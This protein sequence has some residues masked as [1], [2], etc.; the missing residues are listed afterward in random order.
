MTRGANRALG[1]VLPVLAL[2]IAATSCV[3]LTEVP[4]TEVR[5]AFYATPPG[6]DQLVNATYE[7][8]RTFFGRERGFTMTIFGTDEY[9][10]GADGGHKFWNDYD[11]SLNG[12]ASFGRDT[13]TD[14]YLAIN[15]TNA[16]VARANDVPISAALRTLRVAEAR[17]L[18]AFYYFNLVRTFGDVP[19]VVEEALVPKTDAGRDPAAKVYDQIIADL[20]FAKANL[21]AVQKDY[22]RA[23][24]PA[25]QHLLAL[26][27]LTRAQ[28][29]DFALAAA[30]GRAVINGGQFKLLPR[31]ADLFVFG[32]KK[33]DE[34]IWSVQYTADP[35]TT[36]P[37]NNGH[38]FFLMAYELWPGMVRDVQNG[39]AFK[40]FRPT[41]WLLNLWGD[42][43]TTVDTRYDDS[44][45]N[46]WYANNAAT[47]PKKPDGSP[48]FTVGDT[49]IWMPGYLLTPAD[50][51]SRRYQVFSP[52]NY[53]NA[54]FPS[55]KKFEDPNR[56]SVNDERG[57]RDFVL[58]RLA[59]TYLMVA[60]AL[61]RDGK[62]DEAVPF[63]NAVRERAAKTPADRPAM[64]ITAATLTGDPAGIDYVLDERSRELAGEGSRWFD[65]A[66]TGRLVARVK[67]Y[68]AQAAGNIKD[69]HIVRPIPTTQIERT[70]VPFPQNTC[71]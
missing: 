56:L 68:N 25:A 67:R 58:M 36:G 69:C 71:Y 18:R 1:R 19:L 13:W 70:T 49:A 29:G 53:T 24:S 17:F 47:L 38:L 48:K 31:Y 26:V 55:L 60:E 15:T 27:Y 12:D 37:G 21:P 65:L 46:V 50:S 6:F 57:S 63:V 11:A 62:P 44:F 9:T 16:V 64:D 33:N 34:V 66:R 59:D 52:R 54:A 7:P 20:T 23:T 39:R 28:P 35:L 40:R 41:N 22:G 3:N 10:K 61:V 43:R 8:L 51:A 42:V 4:V 45:R 2:V 14:F 32:N 5:S 30:E